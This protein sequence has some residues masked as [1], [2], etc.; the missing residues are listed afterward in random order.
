MI[1]QLIAFSIKNKLIIG[2]LVLALCIWGGYS[3]SQLPIDAVPDITNNQVQVITASPSLGAEEVERLITFPV[4]ITMATIPEIEEI[5][6]FS[7]FGLSVVTIVFKENVDVYWARQQVGE[8]LTQVLTKCLKGLAHQRWRQLL[9]AWE[10]FT[11]M[12]LVTLPGYE[13]EYSPR[14]L[15]TIQDWVVRRQLLGTKGVAGV[16]S[17]GGHLKQYEVAVDPH[18]LH[19]MGVSVAEIF[20]ALKDNNENTGGAYIEKRMNAYFIRT[21]GLVASMEDIRH[22]PIRTNAKGIPILIKDVADV[23]IGSA[24]RMEPLPEMVRGRW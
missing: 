19:A 18:Q 23:Q 17:F 13:S 3:L 21:K 4:E 9:L 7:R 6:S 11:N 10:R 14:E 22:I 5:R 8:R 15:R 2:L 16:S 12:W 24:V 20:R 1:D